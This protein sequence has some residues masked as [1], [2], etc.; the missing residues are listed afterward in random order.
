MSIY[1]HSML[2]LL[3]LF[4]SYFIS[5]SELNMGRYLYFSLHLS[6]LF[7]LLTSY[8]YFNICRHLCRP[9]QL[10]MLP[11]RELYSRAS[12]SCKVVS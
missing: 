12:T 7:S 11:P 8:C 9:R 10:S 2:C 6:F 3:S 5:F 4:S 1:T